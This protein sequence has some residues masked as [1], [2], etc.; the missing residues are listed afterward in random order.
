MKEILFHT[1]RDNLKEIGLNPKDT[2]IFLEGIK[3]I[4][5]GSDLVRNVKGM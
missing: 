4:G 3:R 2:I 5:L 1:I